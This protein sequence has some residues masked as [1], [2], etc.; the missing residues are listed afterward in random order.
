QLMAMD[1]LLREPHESKHDLESFFWLLLWLT[2]RHMD[3]CDSHRTCT[4]LFDEFDPTKACDVKRG[5]LAT[6]VHRKRSVRV[7]D[8]EPLSTLL[9][10][11]M[12]KILDELN[13]LTHLNVLMLF[14]S[15]L[16]GMDWPIDDMAKPFSPQKPDSETESVEP[17]CRSS[18]PK[19]PVP[20]SEAKRS[21]KKAR[22]GSPSGL[23]KLTN[24]R[25][26]QSR[27]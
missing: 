23:K 5:F 12:K 21:Q 7:Q 8:N 9:C 14:E 25:G 26:F 10:E 19:R 17:K 22:K 1:V 24:T 16:G 6:L 3:Y 27:K 4:Q 13:P 15:V 20:N 18:T 2:L 11:F